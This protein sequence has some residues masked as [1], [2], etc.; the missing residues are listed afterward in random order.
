MTE[1]EGT[2]DGARANPSRD[3][4]NRTLTMPACSKHK[5]VFVLI[6]VFLLQPALMPVTQNA[7]QHRNNGLVPTSHSQIAGGEYNNITAIWEN[8]FKAT[9]KTRI[10]NHTRVMSQQFSNRIWFENMTPTQ[11]LQDAWTWANTTLGDNTDGELSFQQV[12][13]YQALVAVKNGTLPE[14][15]TGVIIAGIIDSVET[16]GA[17]DMGVSVAAVLECARILHDFDLGFD[18]YY[19]LTNGHNLDPDY[20]LGARAFV[21]WLEE[22]EIQTLTAFT[23]TRLLFHRVQYL[24]GTKISLRTYD[25]TTD[26]HQTLRMPDLLIS[27]SASYGSSRLQHVSDHGVARDSLA[28]EMW[29]KGRA[30]VHV[31]QGYWHESYSASPADVWNSGDY[32][33]FKATEAVASVLAAIAYIGQMHEGDNPAFYEQGELGNS[34]TTQQVFSDT[35]GGYVNATV[36]WDA[37][38]TLRAEIQRDDTASVVYRR[39]EDDGLIKLRYLSSAIGTYRLVIRNLGSEPTVFGFNLT[40]LSDC[41]GDALSDAYEAILGTNPYSVDSDDDGLT[42]NLELEIGS[43]PLSQDTDNDG[44]LD[45]MEYAIGSSLALNDTD[46]DGLLDGLELELGT[47]PLLA[48]TDADGLNDYEEV[49]VY[50]TDPTNPDTDGDGLEDGFEAQFGLDPLSP[51]SD[52]DTLNDLFE[53]LIGT[54][55]LSSDTDRDGWGDAYEVEYGMLP[56]NVDTDGDFLP[57]GW[58]WNPREHWVNEIAPIS[59]LSTTMLLGIYALMKYKAYKKIEEET[60]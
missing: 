25:K 40:H 42:D 37:N 17:N 5:I 47:N 20:D 52:N 26:Y 27:I 1:T 38:V 14:P 51:D 50:F 11:R 9:S 44:A 2:G 30:A 57:D 10:E 31:A 58:D 8:V 23:F 28:Y 43:D 46:Q 59:L 4:R 45:G 55:A 32:N 54:D 13:E 16:P 22:N 60:G 7:Y 41:D 19:V 49:S 36:W 24:Y 6:V 35:I 39:T 53:V 33:Y 3:S 48:D 18:V 29:E 12:T 56:D 15:R 21:E 34:S